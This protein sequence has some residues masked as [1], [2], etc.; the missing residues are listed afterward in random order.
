MFCSNVF[1][2]PSK[3]PQKL[4]ATHVQLAEGFLFTPRDIKDNCVPWT[5]NFALSSSPPPATVE[6]A[7]SAEEQGPINMDLEEFEPPPPPD[8]GIPSF[9]A[10]NP[11]HF[12]VGEN[13]YQRYR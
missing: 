3:K 1:G 2:I 7:N 10:D 4:K 13:V 12:V 11:R 6:E 9:L 5:T 8:M